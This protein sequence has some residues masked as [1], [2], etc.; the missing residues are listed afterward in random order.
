MFQSLPAPNSVIPMG[1]RFNQA[2]Q[3]CSIVLAL[4]LL[5]PLF[6]YVIIVERETGLLEMQKLMGLHLGTH[7]LVNFLYDQILYYGMCETHWSPNHTNANTHARA[8][9]HRFKGRKFIW[10]VCSLF[11]YFRCCGGGGH[12]CTGIPLAVADRGRHDWAAVAARYCAVGCRACG[13]CMVLGVPV[14]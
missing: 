12:I 9:A 11:V 10:T 3:T 5:L 13:N 8:Q 6:M 7:Y 2:L 4:N 1:T 14:C